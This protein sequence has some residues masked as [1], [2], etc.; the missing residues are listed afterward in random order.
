MEDELVLTVTVDGATGDFMP[1]LPSLPAFNV[2][3]RSSTT[4]I[5]NFHSIVT[6]EFIMLPRFPGKTVIGPITLNYGNKIYKT[7]PITVT[8]YRTPNT[9]QTNTSKSNASKPAAKTAAPPAKARQAEPTPAPA[10]MP[11]LERDLYNSA[12]RNGDKT[13]FMVAALS[14]STPY[15]NQSVTLGIRFYFSSNF[16][17]NAPYNEPSIS[18][19]FME[20]ISTSEGRQK[21][22]NKT[23]GYIERRYAISGVTAGPAQV[24]E[25]SVR[26]IPAGNLTNIS[27]FDRMFAAVSQE[28]QTVRSNPLSLTIRSAPQ[29]GK[30][31][32]FY[33]AVGSGYTISASIDREEVEAGEAVNLTVKVNGSGNLKPTSDLKLPNLPGFKV[34]DVV[35]TSGVVPTNGELKSYKIFKAV[36]VP[37][38]SGTYTIPALD[39]SY[40]DPSAQQYRTIRTQ[41]LTIKAT[42]SSKTDTGFDFATHSELGNGFRELGRDIRYL[43]SDVS[44]SKLGVLS[45]VSDWQI[46]NYLFGALLVLAAL[47]ALMD[48]QT[49]A[50]RRALAKARTQLKN[51]HTEEAVSEALTAYLQARYRVH[52]ASLPLKD[53][54]A[55]LRK[56]GCPAELVQRF[57]TLWQRL[58]AARF[59]PAQM[60]EENAIE[61]AR[62]ATD[63]IKA[64]DKGGRA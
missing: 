51:A 37:L 29:E 40:F 8:V 42:P 10:D 17:D 16:V 44:P 62:Q 43:K 52:I 7:D 41:P 47:F 54:T 45:T 4:Q 1:Q 23:Y 57:D 60:Q 3:A 55:A 28:E 56:N 38:S 53:I 34:Y 64:M 15:V 2:Y 11:P 19:L 21:I 9:P 18:N 32:S 39:W 58:N 6:F 49:L 27:V 59:A 36:V 25:A 22:D 26:Y 33:G 20:L 5:I 48:K 14:D 12:A 30:P 61:L 13:Y 46:A 50:G 24:G 35:A 63:L 31:K